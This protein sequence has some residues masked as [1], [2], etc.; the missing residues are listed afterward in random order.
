MLSLSLG[1][2][3]NNTPE[4][5]L[6]IRV[7]DEA[8]AL[9]ARIDGQVIF[10]APQCCEQLVVLEKS[11]FVDVETL[12]KYLKG[13]QHVGSAD[14]LPMLQANIDQSGTSNQ[15]SSH[16]GSE[17]IYR[18]LLEMSNDIGDLKKMLANLFI[19]CSQIKITHNCLHYL[20]KK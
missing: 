14:N 19:H 1:I 12:K 16:Q 5:R 18:A 17:L 2:L 7:S 20:G 3:S 4:I 13:R 10:M 8:K 15:Q 6:R 11:Q 9:L